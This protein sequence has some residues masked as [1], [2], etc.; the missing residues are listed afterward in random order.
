[1][2]IYYIII[3]KGKINYVYLLKLKI[4]IIELSVSELN[5]LYYCL[6]KVR[7]MKDKMIENDEIDRLMDLVRDGIMSE[8]YNEDELV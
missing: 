6:G 7:D 2:K 3:K 4:M 1:L 8:V 5:D